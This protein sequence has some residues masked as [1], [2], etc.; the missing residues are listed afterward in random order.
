MA[1]DDRAR[2]VFHGAIVLLV[3]LLCGL[4]TVIEAMHESE[5]FWHTAHEALIM[6]GVWMLAASSMLPALVLQR[7]EAAGLVWSFLA[8]GYSFATALTAMGAR[9]ALR[10]SRGP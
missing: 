2:L 6:M 4:P 5:R 8:M 9:A 10:A 1:R 3:G 7:R